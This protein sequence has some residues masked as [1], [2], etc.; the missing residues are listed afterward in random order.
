MARSAQRPS[1]RMSASELLELSVDELRDKAREAGITGFS[2]MRKAELVE[3]LQ[4]TR[5]RRSSRDN[6]GR[7]RRGPGSSAS[8]KYSQEISSPDGEPE[9]EGRSLLTTNHEVIL[10]W[11]QERGGVPASVPGTEREGHLGILRIDFGGQD[12]DLQQVDWE[13]WFETFDA[14]GLNF[15]YQEQRSDGRQSNFFRL[16][17]PNREDG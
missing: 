17:N 1:R 11:A 16:E 14:R 7:V 15:L 5:P 8:L 2:R 12:G 9:R 10:R 3:A 4:D 13:Q 6:G